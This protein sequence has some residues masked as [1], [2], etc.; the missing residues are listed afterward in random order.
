MNEW[1]NERVNDW[2]EI[3]GSRQETVKVFWFWRASIVSSQTVKAQWDGGEEVN[4]ELQGS[5]FIP[6]K[7]PSQGHRGHLPLW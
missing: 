3:T 6:L 5:S 7:F 1:T 2:G 4:N